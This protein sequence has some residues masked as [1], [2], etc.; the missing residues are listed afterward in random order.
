[1]QLH[2]PSFAMQ[3]SGRVSG[4]GSGHNRRLPSGYLSVLSTRSLH[5][6]NIIPI[7]EEKH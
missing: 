3:G 2:L 4:V 1:M 6:P 5:L 7:H